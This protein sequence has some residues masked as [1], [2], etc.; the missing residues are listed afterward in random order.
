MR[1]CDA[2]ICDGDDLRRERVTSAVAAVGCA[3]HQSSALS[4]LLATAGQLYPDIVII[5]FDVGA[6][7]DALL[8]VATLRATDRRLPVLLVSTDDSPRVVLAALRAGVK[9]FLNPYDPATLAESVRCCL[10]TAA[11]RAGRTGV[12]AARDGREAALVGVSRSMRAIGEYLTRVAAHD[13]TVLITGETGTGKE[14]AAARIHEHSARRGARFVS[15]NC[16]AIPESL[17]ESELFGYEG[18]A[19]TGAVRARE[20]LLQHANRGTVFLDEVGDL[21][22][23]AQAK[24]LRAIET[25]EVYRLGGKRPEKLDLRIVA[26]TNQD[27]DRAVEDGRFRKDLYFRLNVA[28]IHLPPLRERRADIVPLLEHYLQAVNGRQ[29]VT[30]DGFGAD[31]IAALESYDWPG[32]VRELKNL[33]EAIFVCPP[34]GTIGVAD[35]PD[36]FRRRLQQVCSLPDADRRRVLEALLTAKWNKSKAATLLKCSRMTLYRKMS[37]Y[38]FVSSDEHAAKL[39]HLPVAATSRKRPV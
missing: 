18:G 8:A 11:S 32:N 28:R 27:L 16:A 13:A 24:I 10:A 36:D 22:L 29:G 17:I 5:A 19:F 4:D 39:S 20:G 31:A 35:L 33:V 37:K 26:A 23:S 25:R 14:L 6:A 30:V 12:P 15:V 21:G 1:R 9:D 2:L 34:R 38:S 3:C 7:D